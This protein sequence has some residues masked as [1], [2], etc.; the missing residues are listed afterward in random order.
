MLT[1][2]RS[3]RKT[4]ID[5]LIDEEEVPT[6]PVPSSQASVSR[7]DFTYNAETFQQQQIE[8][9]RWMA[10]KMDDMEEKINKKETGI[11]IYNKHQ[12]VIQSSVVKITTDSV[13][14]NLDPIFTLSYPEYQG[15]VFRK[16]TSKTG[17]LDELQLKELKPKVS[18]VM[19]S[20]RGWIRKI[21][22]L[23]LCQLPV[24]EK[25]IKLGMYDRNGKIIPDATTWVSINDYNVV[26]RTIHTMLCQMIEADMTRYNWDAVIIKMLADEIVICYD[27][28][29]AKT[30]TECPKWFYDT[31]RVEY[32]YEFWERTQN[33]E[34]IQQA[35][36]DFLRTHLPDVSQ[37]NQ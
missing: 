24:K 33:R 4:A 16:L 19:A 6:N 12:S 23:A 17:T 7:P 3:K 8:I 18:D 32:V 31:K 10:K 5:S 29:R 1:I 13:V 14:T 34:R 30:P 15:Y 21:T 25:Q 26:G 36:E 11:D 2:R 9:Q 35:R 20:Y 28:L 37:N 22:K 27:K